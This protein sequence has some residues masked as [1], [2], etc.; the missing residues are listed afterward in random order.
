MKVAT[1]GPT[2]ILAG[3]KKVADERLVYLAKLVSAVKTTFIQVEFVESSNLLDVDGILCDT[4]AKL[5]LVIQDLELLEKLLGSCDAGLKPTLEEIKTSLEKE[6]PLSQSGISREKLAV[7][8]G[9]NLV[10]L[11]PIVFYATD[12]LPPE[13]ELIKSM[14]AGMGRISFFT[15]APKD[16]HAWSIKRGTNAYEA[17][18]CVHSDIQ[19]GF[20]KAEVLAYEAIVK[21]GG[22]NQAKAQGALRLEEK[23]YIVQD[24]DVLHFRFSA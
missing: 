14:Y 5:D 12:S 4:S 24:G 23:E 13:E 20:I 1:V 3:K 6:I 18:G 11:K 10:T 21:V 7:L 22:I 16:T 19:R 2:C 17:A 9:H 8:A 15:V